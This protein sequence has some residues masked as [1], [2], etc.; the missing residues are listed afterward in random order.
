MADSKLCSSSFHNESH[1][2]RQT[3][4]YGGWFNVDEFI[5]NPICIMSSLWQGIQ[6][7]SSRG[8]SA[9][10]L[11][12]NQLHFIPPSHQRSRRHPSSHK[13]TTLNRCH[14]QTL[15]LNCFSLIIYERFQ[16]LSTRCSWIKNLGSC[17]LNPVWSLDILKSLQKLHHD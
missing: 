9:N 12:D 10:H 11:S 5:L 13:W 6:P 4:R 15:D 16:A 14:S 1:P 17:C 3:W 7:F 8:T 2:S